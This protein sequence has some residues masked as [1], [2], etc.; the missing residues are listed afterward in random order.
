M[1]HTGHNN[2]KKNHLSPYAIIA[3]F[4]I[5]IMPTLSN[6][7]I[8]TLSKAA[9]LID[10]ESGNVLYEKDSDLSIPPASMSKM[11]TVYLVFDA[12]KRGD[13]KLTDE[14]QVSETAWRQEGSRMFLKLNDTVTVEN[15]LH[16]AIIQSGNDACVALAEGLSGS[17]DAFVTRMNEM[18]KKLKLTHSSFA[19][20]TGLPDVNHY[21][22]VYDLALLG[23]ALVYDFPEYYKIYSKKEFTWNNIKQGNRNPLLYSFKGADG[24]KTGH[25]EEAGFCLVG[26]AKRDNMRLIS[27]VSGLKSDKERRDESIKLLGYGFSEFKNVTFYNTH[28]IATLPIYLGQDDSVTA[29]LDKNLSALV[30]KTDYAKITANIQYETPLVA[31]IK[32]GDVIGKVFVTIPNQDDTIS[33]NI[34][35]DNAVPQ[36]SFTGRIWTSLSYFLFGAPQ[37]D[38]TKNSVK[39][40]AVLEK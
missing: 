18:A 14:F 8:T 33:T 16:G 1:H 12:L 13:I 17:L 6:A 22:S 19:N 37:F 3:T 28:S 27:V 10:A 4:I 21:M 38:T 9:V 7:E 32:K 34:I 5:S 36:A 26:S 30:K 11:M 24:L 2:M 20:P 25:T 35:A 29:S 31:P 15:L 23:R 40:D 39:S